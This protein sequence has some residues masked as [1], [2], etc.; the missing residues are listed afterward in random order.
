MCDSYVWHDSFTCVTW[1]I[2]VC[3]MT[4]FDRAVLS[5]TNKQSLSRSCCFSVSL[6]FYLSR[7]LFRSLF[8]SC[9]LS[10]SHTH[11]LCLPP[12]PCFYL[13][14]SFHNKCECVKRPIAGVIV[15]H[16]QYLLSLFLSLF[17]S[18]CLA[19]S[20]SSSF[21]LS[22]R[23]YLPLTL[24]HTLSSPLLA[25]SVLPFSLC[26]SHTHTCS[27]SRCPNTKSFSRTS[28]TSWLRARPSRWKPPTWI[29]RSPPLRG[30]SWCVRSTI[31]DLFWT[32]PM[33]VGEDMRG[34]L[35]YGC[36]VGRIYMNVCIHTCV[37]SRQTQIDS[38]WMWW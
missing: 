10:L 35:F 31:P 3:G 12:P 33:P 25:P 8:V 11:S 4:Q 20:L 13:S 9:S 14:C 21:C 6:F 1:L 15:A 24:F 19:L 34:C 38:D 28:A 17:L 26:L 27:Q 18:R 2:N 37:W 16:P 7:S 5:V 29:P 23:Y 36:L 32:L 30:R 22:P